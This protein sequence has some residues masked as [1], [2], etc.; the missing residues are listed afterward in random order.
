MTGRR[1]IDRREP[2]RLARVRDPPV[3]RVDAQRQPRVR[4]DALHHPA[5]AMARAYDRVTFVG[6]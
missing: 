6:A 4:T 3:E 2:V 1:R 5:T